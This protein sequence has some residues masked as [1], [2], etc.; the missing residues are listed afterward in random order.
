MT[1]TFKAVALA[2]VASAA[3][4][5][6]AQAQ[7]MAGEW[8]GP[9][10]GALFGYAK[11][12]DNTGEQV[13]FDKNLDGQYGDTVTT[14]AGANAFSP[15]F[16]DGFAKGP[17]AAGG[18][19]GDDDTGW[20]IGLR[21]GY[22]WQIGNFVIGGVAEIERLRLQDDVTAFSTTPA[23]YSFDRKLKSLAVLRLRGGYAM[24]P[25]LAYAT[26]GVAR[27]DVEHAFR[28]SNTVNTFVPKPD[29]NADGY[30]VGVGLERQLDGR[31][32]LGLEYL[33]TRL[34]DDSGP[35]RVQGPAPATNPFILTNAAGTDMQ[36]GEDLIEVHSVRMTASYRF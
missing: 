6:V 10:V 12:A 8:S 15:G 4:A 20:E 2:L 16:C 17:T 33:Y 30:Q 18:C 31:V 24:G 26:G 27:G 23:F 9:Y 3:C 35:V 11:T 36:R 7:G 34:E 1:K 22:D 25:Y 19:V 29:D 32:R 13:V 21:G 14:A 5:G 28:S